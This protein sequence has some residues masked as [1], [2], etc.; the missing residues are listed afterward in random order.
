MHLDASRVTVCSFFR[1][2]FS[3]TLFSNVIVVF[4]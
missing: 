1:F 3:K 2:V 4:V